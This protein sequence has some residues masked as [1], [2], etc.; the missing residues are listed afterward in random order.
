VT[1]TGSVRTGL[2]FLR[3][4][5]LFRDTIRHPA[6][7]V[8]LSGL[9]MIIRLEIAG[10]SPD[11]G[12]LDVFTDNRKSTYALGLSQSH[13]RQFVMRIK[14]PRRVLD[15]CGCQ[16]ELRQDKGE[17]IIEANRLH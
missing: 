2:I 1:K 15:D 8:P 6:D 5:E 7:I 4:Y 9:N 17:L 12:G 14:S 13:W 16:Y 10:E 11:S 3:G